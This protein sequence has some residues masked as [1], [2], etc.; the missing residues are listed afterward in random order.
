MPE[1]IINGPGGRLEARYHHESNSD[2]P[3]AQP[4]KFQKV[5]GQW[6]ISNAPDGTMIDATSFGNVFSAHTLYFF[7][8]SGDYLVPDQRWFPSGASTPTRVVKALLGN[9]EAAHAA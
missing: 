9:G 4:Y 2:S 5:G 8:P 7:D 3:I 6:R 1:L